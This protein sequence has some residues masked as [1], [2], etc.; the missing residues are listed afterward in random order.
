MTDVVINYCSKMFYNIG[1]SAYFTPF[2]IKIYHF[3]TCSIT[4]SC[5]RCVTCC[6]SPGVSAEKR[7]LCNLNNCREYEAAFFFV[8]LVSP[9]DPVDSISPSYSS[10]SYN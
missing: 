2:K 4:V 9:I 7:F 5:T 10:L 8:K 6:L 3:A 1:T